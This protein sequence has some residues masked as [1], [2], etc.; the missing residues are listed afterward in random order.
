M[1]YPLSYR[2]LLRSLR[3]S[4][5]H[6]SVPSNSVYRPQ[7]YGRNQHYALCTCL[8]Q[9]SNLH[10]PPPEGGASCQLGYVGSGIPVG[11]RRRTVIGTHLLGSLAPRAGLEPTPSGL[12]PDAL[13]IE[14]P[15]FDMRLSAPHAPSDRWGAGPAVPRPVLPGRRSVV[16]YT[17]PREGG[18]VTP[19]FPTA[20]PHHAQMTTAPL[21]GT[22]CPRTRRSQSG[23]AATSP[24]PSSC[25]PP[26]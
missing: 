23:S 17:I 24:G 18:G 26:C 5:R 1:L 2:A 13:P 12:E 15:R 4:D 22:S 9:D 16:F 6:A 10:C 7:R 8:Q 20:T 14:L 3:Q 19:R 11:H 25:T 21:L